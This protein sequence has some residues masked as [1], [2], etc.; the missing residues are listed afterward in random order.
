MGLRRAV[1]CAAM[2]LLGAAGSARAQQVDVSR[3]PI[4]I[5]R[6]RRELNVA[7]SDHEQRDGL[8]LRYQIEVYGRA[9]AITLFTAADN[10]KNGPVP[11]GAPTHRE[12]VDQMTPQE[13]RAPIMDFSAL[14]K[15]LADKTK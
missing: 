10:L 12:M 13:F 2:V 14:F 15:W 11:Y 1:T 6:I 8:N 7:L 3:L 5:E 4:N 9:P